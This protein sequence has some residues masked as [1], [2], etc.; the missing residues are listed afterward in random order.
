[1]TES[2]EG[3]AGAAGADAAFWFVFRGRE[4]LVR[5]EGETLVVPLLREPGELGIEPLR[6]LELEEVEGV[7][8][9]AAE[10]A[11]SFAPP[12]G[13]EF[14]GLRAT[15]GLLGDRHFRM[16]GRAVQLVDW[17]RT[18]RFCGHCGTPTHTLAHE[19]ARECPNCGLVA[20]PRL[21]PAI[22]VLVRRGRRVLLGRSHATP[23]GMYSTLAGFV[24]PGESLEEAVQ[25]EIGEEVGITVRGIRYFGSQPWPFPNSLMIG[26]TAEHAGGEIRVDEVEMEDAAWFDPEALPNLPPPISIARALID[27]YLRDV[28][29]EGA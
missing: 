20:Y 9:R 18:H 4:L 1:M 11:E 15:Y 7:P 23:P 5:V 25:R 14:R 13:M 22:I 28:G 27:A 29:M 3:E 24:E 26:F 12:A 21:S 16:A 10:V 17:D 6:L 8:T 19:H 2:G